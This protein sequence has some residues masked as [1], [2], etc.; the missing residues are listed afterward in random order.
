MIMKLNGLVILHTLI[1][2]L[3]CSPPTGSR[4][5]L[6]VPNMKTVELVESMHG[7]V[8]DGVFLCGP[9]SHEMS[10]MSSGT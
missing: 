9:F 4:L 1:R 7:D 6:T 8:Y 5:A 10:W 2:Q 3:V